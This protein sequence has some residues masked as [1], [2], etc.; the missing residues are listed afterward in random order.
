MKKFKSLFV[1]VAVFALALPLTSVANSDNFNAPAKPIVPADGFYNAANNSR[2]PDNL[3]KGQTS[4]VFSGDLVMNSQGQ[5]CATWIAS[6]VISYKPRH[7]YFA[8]WN[9]SA[10]A[11]FANQNQPDLV[12]RGTGPPK[13]ALDKFDQPHIVWLKDIGVPT[14]R[15]A[16]YAHWNGNAWSGQQALD[17]DN[18]SAGFGDIG[19]VDIAINPVNQ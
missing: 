1:L 8:C 15:T 2:T 14:L 3:T 12:G 7:I 17:Y 4:P 16:A 6:D 11:G 19:T 10:W 18:V 9:G 5:P 13:M